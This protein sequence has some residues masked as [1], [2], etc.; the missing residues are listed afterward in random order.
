[1]KIILMLTLLSV[2][3]WSAECKLKGQTLKEQ[4]IETSFQTSDIEACKALAE[5]TKANNFFS[6]VE[7]D[8]M[9]SDTTMLFREDVTSKET[10][11]FE[12][13]SSL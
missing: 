10:I 9:L 12:D 2:S 4:T 6:L 1:M 11:S 13:E 7:K 8:D 3:A 5:Q